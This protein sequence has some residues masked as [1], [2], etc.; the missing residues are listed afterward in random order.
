MLEI[1]NFMKLLLGKP[2]ADKILK[3]LK[4]KIKKSRT[5]P[6]LAVILVG[7]NL[8]S[9]LYVNLKKKAA[10]KVGIG[11]SVFR[12]SAGAKE[13][14]IIEKIKRLNNDKKVS[15]IIVQ[16]PLPNN[17]N[18]QRIINTINPKKDVDGFSAKGSPRFGEAGGHLKPVF[19]NAILE[20]IKSSKIKLNG[21]KAIIIANSGKFGEIVKK[22]LKTESIKAQYIL[23]KD[24]NKN[25]NKI[26]K[27]DI[28][29]SAVG[30]PKLI[31]GN[32]IKEGAIIIDGGITKKGKKVL[33]D[34]DFESV[35]KV[36]SYISPVPGGVGPVTVACLLR[37]VY[38]AGKY[39][40]K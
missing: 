30:K 23:S 7:N 3:D 1:W 17:L 13:N 8:A 31:K 33:G 15:G 9:K 24:F 22:M 2:I 5:R 14:A 34:V 32:M 26:K 27:A 16:L 38:L 40:S 37:N 4:D 6:A 39:Q 35:K 29:I 11:F 28:V 36:A 25:A 18:T 20:L 19:P 10:K 12:F 21:K